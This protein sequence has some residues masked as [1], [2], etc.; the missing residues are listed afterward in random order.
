M[1]DLH[2]H[3]SA[4]DGILSPKESAE[5]AIGK[6]LKVWALTDHD[7]VDGL[8]EAAKTCEKSESEIIFIPGIEINIR[9]PT[10]EFHL[11]GLGLR[12]YSEDLKD[13]VADLT[14][15][16]RNRNLE[17]VE[18]MNKDGIEV[19]LEDIEGLFA[20]SQIGR[21][22]FASYLMKIGKV[23]H[24]Q[25]AFDRFLGKGRPYYA[26]HDGADLDVAVEAIRSAGGVPVLAHPLSLY[27]SWGKMDETIEKIKNHGVEGLEAWHPA[28]RI[29]EGF[30]LEQLAKKLGMFVTAGS[31]FHGK[32]VRAD[33]HLGKTSGDRKIEDRF[34]FEELLPHLGDFDWRKTEWCKSNA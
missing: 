16:R 5:Y 22:H 24:R 3:S 33:R 27:V 10:G 32:G 13:L 7:T 34:Y 20:E 1:I 26:T 31:D 28:A 12:R 30:K 21:P 11:L 15:S 18:K 19:T 29:N 9:W 2:S 4:S 8:S 17:I 14:E 6:N 25:E 23:K